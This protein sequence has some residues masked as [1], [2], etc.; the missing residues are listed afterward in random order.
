MGNTKIYT[1]EGLRS[2]GQARIDLVQLRRAFCSGE[3]DGPVAISESVNGVQTGTIQ[4]SSMSADAGIAYLASVYR[5]LNVVRVDADWSDVV[6]AVWR[7]GRLIEELV[8]EPSKREFFARDR[9]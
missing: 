9:G 6:V 1:W 3:L 2:R 7:G 4:S 8:F 5:Y